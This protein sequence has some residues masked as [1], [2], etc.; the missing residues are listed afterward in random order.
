MASKQS[1]EQSSSKDT[2]GLKDTLGSKKDNSKAS[3][4]KSR[5][6]KKVNSKPKT[7]ELTESRS[8]SD[9]PSICFICADPITHYAIGPCDHRCCFKC[10][11]RSRALYKSRLCPV[12]KSEQP[13]VIF[14]ED[15]EKKFDAFDLSLM[16]CDPRL[17]I[18]FDSTEAHNDTL[19]LLRFNCPY[20]KCTFVSPEGYL[21]LKA[22]AFAMHNKNFCELCVTHKKVFCCE[23]MLYSRDEL[24]LHIKRGSSVGK[25]ASKAKDD[26]FR[27]HP[28]C[29]FCK[30]RFYDSDALY[31]HCRKF[32]EECFLCKRLNPADHSLYQD[33][34]ALEEHFATEHFLC[35][36]RE[37][38]EKR[39]VVFSSEID[40]QAHNVE[41]HSGKYAGFQR[42]RQKQARQI[43]VNLTFGERDQDGSSGLR[44]RTRP[45]VQESL[46]SSQQP[47]S[48][49]FR[50]I[51]APAGFGMPTVTQTE[52]S[53]QLTPVLTALNVS[54]PA[55][56]LG[57]S[58]PSLNG[59]PTDATA[60]SVHSPLSSHSKL[61]V[62]NRNNSESWP[63]LPSASSAPATKPK[64]Q[65]AKE[66]YSRQLLDKRPPLPKA[67]PQP[68]KL[69][70]PLSSAPAG[71]TKE[72]FIPFPAQNTIAG[73]LQRDSEKIAIF[74]NI[75]D[76]FRFGEVDA[77]EF[78]NQLEELFKQSGFNN[79]KDLSNVLSKVV[80]TL[81]ELMDKNLARQ[82]SNA[83][84]KYLLKATAFPELPSPSKPSS[85][86]TGPRRVLVIKD[87]PLGHVQP[88]RN[89]SKKAQAGSAERS[90][91]PSLPLSQ[92]NVSTSR[93]SNP[94]AKAKK[95][96]WANL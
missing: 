94:K 59:F 43:N 87:K 29:V 14:S 72:W 25:R 39:F 40:L 16:S 70:P 53:T 50:R 15:P 69:P 66:Q 44:P 67:S 27:G 89:S 24:Q 85:S 60:P 8:N 5:L 33:Y 77:S 71:S 34:H 2:P 3:R 75:V 76:L 84:S 58:W 4:P 78:I 73:F 22:H 6:P 68:T 56:T 88:S 93:A 10:C 7:T 36:E 42:V 62:V 96:A 13:F 28:Y 55:E 46:P 80:Q 49:S 86:Q 48:E 52:L 54:E 79:A 9:E 18:Y 74:Y 1:P 95:I 21:V 26:G 92:N 83:L 23:H 35:N 31:E 38:L 57:Q 17:D 65:T 30:M 32:H 20:E 64:P 51:R 37:C 47:E 63:E 90:E 12:C 19:D 91:F 61:K 81:V 82:L 41:E 11:L 45:N